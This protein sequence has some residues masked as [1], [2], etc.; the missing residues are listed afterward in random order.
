MRKKR[1]FIQRCIHIWH[2]PEVLLV[3][4][5]KKYPSL[6]N[7]ERYMR[8]M[9]KQ[10]FG[11]DF[12]IECPRTFNEKLNWL[13]LHYRHPMYT[14][15][16]DKYWVKKYVAH[17]IGKEYVVPCYGCWKHFREIDFQ[18]LP[19]KFFMKTNHD[20]RKGVVVDKTVGI[21][22]ELLK[23]MFSDFNLKNNFYWPNREWPYK[24]IEPC[25]LAEKLLENGRGGD[26]QDYKFWCF[27]GV[28]QFMYITNKGEIIKENFYDMEFRPVEINHGFPRSEPEF[29]KPLNFNLMRE[30]AAIL[31]KGIPFVR[32]DFFEVDGKVYFG[33][34]TFYDWGGMGLFADKETDLKLGDL[35]HLPN[36]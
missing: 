25:I 17:L 5:M 26:L 20:S 32:V 8:V 22:Y 7:D 36:E 6:F 33:E 4:L 28:P 23:R 35:I 19:D 30:L 14:L 9:T 21:D 1:S 29:A 34:F 18:S 24:N 31:S 27:N 12:D 13:K 3:G 16:A 2:D 15:M 11:D 10:V